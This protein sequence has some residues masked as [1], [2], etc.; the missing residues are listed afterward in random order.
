MLLLIDHANMLIECAKKYLQD[1][2][3]KFRYAG[4][5]KDVFCTDGATGPSSAERH[6]KMRWCLRTAAWMRFRVAAGQVLP[7]R[8]ERVPVAHC[9]TEHGRS[10]HSHESCAEDCVDSWPIVE[11]VQVKSLFRFPDCG[12]V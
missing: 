2:S 8:P 10:G 11:R 12:P 6:G 1:R 5:R 3:E 7:A 4:L 9:P